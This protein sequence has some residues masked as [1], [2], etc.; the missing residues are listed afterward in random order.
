MTFE[1]G[2]IRPANAVW[3]PQ[4]IVFYGP[5][6][7][8]KTVFG[9][10]CESPILLRVEDGAGAIDVPTFPELVTDWQNFDDIFVALYGDHPFKTLIIDS[11]DWLE[12]IAWNALMQDRSQNEKGVYVKSI[13]D[14]G[15]GKGYAMADAYWRTLLW[16]LDGLRKTMGMN[17]VVLAH[18]EVKPHSPPESETYDR[19]QLKLHKRASGL[20][21]EW[22]DMVLFSNFKST[23]K[24]TEEGFKKEVRKGVG[25]GERIIHTERRPAF[26][27]KNRWGL[28]SEILI[29]QD[30]TWSAFHKALNDATNGQYFPSFGK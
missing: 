16:K 6:G 26:E 25:T 1:L 13:E 4:K 30:K 27:A 24:R 23:I 11:V 17:I 3:V 22:A 8:G 10:T 18:S 19:Y 28:P 2:N 14:Y 7:L 12:P 15:F 21:Q 5:Q 20:W 9:S 29:G